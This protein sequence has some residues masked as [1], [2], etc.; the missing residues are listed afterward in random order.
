MWRQHVAA[1]CD[2]ISVWKIQQ[3]SSTTIFGA[4]QVLDVLG[5]HPCRSFI[6]WPILFAGSSCIGPSSWQVLHLLASFL[7]RFFMY[8]AIIFVTHQVGVTLF[9]CTAVVTRNIVL[10]NG[11]GMLMLLCTI[12]LDGFVIIKRYIH[13]WVVW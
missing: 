11:A 12:L 1:A 5:N 10:A 2:R 7:C 9:R 8:W 4:L 6:S 3:Y 13:P